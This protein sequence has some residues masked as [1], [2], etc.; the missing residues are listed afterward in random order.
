MS[1]WIQ[2][3]VTAFGDCRAIGKFFKLD[4]ENDIHYIDRFGFSF[5][6][7]NVPGMRFGKLVEQNPNLV[8]LVRQTTDYET[9]WLL[10]RFDTASNKTQQIL[11]EQDGHYTEGYPSSINKRILIE[12]T[13]EFPTLPAKHLARQKGFEEFRWKMFFDYGKISFMLSQADKYE[14]MAYIMA[15][16][17]GVDF[18]NQPLD[19]E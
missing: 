2:Y 16:E 8:F 7:K 19:V 4:P 14:E 13:E 18:D 6:Q 3:D 10:E 12:Y 17:F 5:G 9:T 1:M 15:D 11:V